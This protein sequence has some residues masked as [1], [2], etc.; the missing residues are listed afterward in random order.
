M[1]RGRCADGMAA[2][3]HDSCQRMKKF[4]PSVSMFWRRVGRTR[5]CQKVFMSSPRIWRS[6]RS[7]RGV[8]CVSQ[9]LAPGRPCGPRDSPVSNGRG[10]RVARAGGSGKVCGGVLSLWDPLLDSSAEQGTCG[11][12]LSVRLS[13]ASP[14]AV[15]QLRGAGGIRGR[16]A[17]SGT[18]SGTMVTATQAWVTARR[19][20]PAALRCRWRPV[21]MRKPSHPRGIVVNMFCVICRNILRR[22]ITMSQSVERTSLVLSRSGL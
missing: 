18:R 15:G 3:G 10:C 12:P 9:R 22:E 17:A 14:S 2:K 5:T 13:A 8:S 6:C 1:H 7:G 11:S 4:P 16:C 20:R 21:R 19:L